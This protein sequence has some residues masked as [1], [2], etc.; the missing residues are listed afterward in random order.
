MQ[1]RTER[2]IETESK[3]EAALACLLSLQS[4][5]L[6][7]EPSVPV[8]SCRSWRWSWRR[9]LC[10]FVGL[11]ALSLLCPAYVMRGLWPVATVLFLCCLVAGLRG[12][13]T[14]VFVRV[15]SWRTAISPRWTTGHKETTRTAERRLQG[16]TRLSRPTGPQ[17]A[18]AQTTAPGFSAFRRA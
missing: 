13:L 7:R 9:M 16:T 6:T 14:L 5:K 3:D 10:P 17:A 8:R 2:Q 15:T 18:R 11:R 1:R 4:E 12:L